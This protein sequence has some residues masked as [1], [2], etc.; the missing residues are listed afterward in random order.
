MPTKRRTYRRRR[1]YNLRRVRINTELPLSTLASDTALKVGL[2]GA[3]DITYRAITLK[4]TWTLKGLTQGEGPITVGY[5]HSDYSVAEIKECIE[6]FASISPGLKIEQERA[7]RQ[8]RVVG[9]FSSEVNSSLQDGRLIKTRLNW[10]LPEGGGSEVV[11][12]AFNE[13]TTAISTGSTVN[14]NGNM[15]VKDSV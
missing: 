7:N 11:M 2:T 6:S 15:W 1:A 3:S 4:G 13:Q 5:A 9:T 14:F 8:I 12:F 10:L